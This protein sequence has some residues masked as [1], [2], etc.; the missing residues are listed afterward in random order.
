MIGV[1]VVML[2]TVFA[3]SLQTTMADRVGASF[4][5]D[6]VVTSGSGDSTGFDPSLAGR[7]AALP[8]VA[9][10]AGMGSGDVQVDGVGHTVH[11][12]DPVALA[13][14]VRLRVTGGSLTALGPGS[15]AVSAGTGLHVGS[16]VVL[17]YADGT[18]RTLTVGAVYRSPDVAGSY[19]LPR[20]AWPDPQARDSLIFVSLHPGAAGRAAVVRAVAGSGQPSVR[21]RAE[22]VDDQTAQVRNLLAVVYVM[23][24][25]AIVI[26]LLGIANTLAL[27]VHE[28]TRELGLLRAVGATRRQAR[29]M[30]RWESVLVASFGVLGGLFLGVFVGWG[31]VTAAGDGFAVPAVQTVV[32]VLVGVLAGVLAAVRPARR[33]ARTPL[34]AALTSP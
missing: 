5:G 30:I 10:A 11:V 1:G 19:L 31:L 20:S 33:A 28:R 26:A 12:A 8:P 17:R 2:F 15:L 32:I 25:L 13:R 4:A 27:A 24:A 21:T 18:S 3:A 9:A 23:L 14:V 22:Y 29:S 7:V 6:L 34:I 16:R